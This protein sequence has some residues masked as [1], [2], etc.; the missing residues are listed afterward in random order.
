MISRLERDVHPLGVNLPV[1][2]DA[3]W[4]LGEIQASVFHWV[5]TY[6]HVTWIH[7]DFDISA[8]PW[9]VKFVFVYTPTVHWYISKF[10]S[11]S[12]TGSQFIPAVAYKQFTRLVHGYMG[13]KQFP[14]PSCAYAAIQEKFK[15]DDEDFVLLK[16]RPFW[17]FSLVYF[18]LHFTLRRVSGGMWT[19]KKIRLAIFQLFISTQNPKH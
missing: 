6:I 12:P 16:N 4:K 15:S 19:V 14:L 10:T 8:H 11:F 7:S 1:Q 17:S 18:K 5:F 9:W 13:G 3:R 2:S